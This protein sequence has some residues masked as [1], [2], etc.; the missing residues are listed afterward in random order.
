[1]VHGCT[2]R[3]QRVN[4]ESEEVHVN[5]LKSWQSVDMYNIVYQINRC[6][7]FTL[8]RHIRCVFNG[9]MCG[10]ENFTRTVTNYGVC[11]T[12]NSIHMGNSKLIKIPGKDT[13]TLMAHILLIYEHCL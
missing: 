3:M 8:K 2:R 9:E 4:V 10:P 6:F 13:M 1:M 11:Y 7:V 5:Q 12:F